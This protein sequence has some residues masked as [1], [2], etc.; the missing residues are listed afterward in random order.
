M[1]MMDSLE[2]RSKPRSIALELG[3]LTS[4]D[5]QTTAD[6]KSLAS[7]YLEYVVVIMVREPL[8]LELIQGLTINKCNKLM[9]T[10]VEHLWL[11]SDIR[12]LYMVEKKKNSTIRNSAQCTRQSVS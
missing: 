6:R 8:K 5:M 2:P 11:W 12:G 10:G 9:S 1:I 7:S 4:G 3:Q